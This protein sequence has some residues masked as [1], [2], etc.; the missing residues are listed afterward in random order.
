MIDKPKGS[1]VE[2]TKHRPTLNAVD[3]VV[4]I[5]KRSN[6]E[7]NPN[8]AELVFEQDHKKIVPEPVVKYL[9]INLDR[10]LSFGRHV[11]HIKVPKA[12]KRK[13]LYSTVQSIILYGAPIWWRL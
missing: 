4:K 11:D 12:K 6:A 13:V 1:P 7:G 5:A 3:E 8:I 9:G 2:E 10:G